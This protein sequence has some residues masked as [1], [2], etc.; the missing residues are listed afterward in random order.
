MNPNK[1]TIMIKDNIAQQLIDNFNFAYMIIV[2]LI[3]YFTI[4]FIDY[5]NEDKEVKTITKRIVLL[6]VTIIC[7]IIYKTYTEIDSIVLIN[8][9]VLAPVF[10]SWILRPIMKKLGLGYKSFDKYLD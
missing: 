4:K 9:S 8:S 10:W 2:N 6:I 3:T 1:N 5:A 7:F